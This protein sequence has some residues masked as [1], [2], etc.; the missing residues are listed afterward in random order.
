MLLSQAII[1]NFSSTN[2]TELKHVD[3]KKMHYK[4]VKTGSTKHWTN[5]T[6][7]VLHLG[8]SPVAHSY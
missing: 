3:M 1:N 2:M 5:I 8:G 6:G 7:P 4:R